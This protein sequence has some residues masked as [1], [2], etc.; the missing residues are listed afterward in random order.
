MRKT[1]ITALFAA[2]AF[3]PAIAHHAG[4]QFR[5]SDE[6]SVGHAYTI[7]NAPMAQAMR[8]YLTVRNEGDEAVEVTGA[9]VDFAQDVRFMAQTVKDGTLET[10][11]LEKIRVDAG[12]TLTMQPGAVWIE[13]DG[14][15]ETFEHG[16]HF[17][18]TLAFADIGSVEIEVEVEETPGATPSDDHDHDH[19]S[20]EV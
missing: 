2:F 13:L 5:V 8:V 4:E 20:G 17:H 9:S 11:N 12:Q 19:E 7:E 1:V 3:T 18:M 10:A 15:Q 16:E 6:V 14:V